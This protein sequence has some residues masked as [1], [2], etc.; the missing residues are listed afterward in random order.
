MRRKAPFFFI[1]LLAWTI[2]HSVR[3]QLHQAVTPDKPKA[4]VKQN[5]RK[6]APMET[7][8]QF[9]NRNGKWLRGMIHW[10][11]VSAGGAVPGVILFHGFTGDRN[12]SHWI[13]VKCAR[14]LQQGGIAALRFDFYGSGESEG[15]FKEMTLQGE[16]ADAEDAVGFL[17]AQNGIAFDRIGLGGL[18][19]GGTVAAS[20]AGPA[21]ARALVLWSAVAHPDHLGRTIMKS[22]KAIPNGRGNLEYDAREISAEFLE[23]LGKVNPLASVMAFKGPTLIL[24]PGKDEVVPL[25]DAEEFLNSAGAAVKEKVVIAGANHTYTSIAWENEVIQRTVAW[26]RKYL[27]DN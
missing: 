26:F 15:P 13:F 16:I 5:E 7:L 21:Q 20:I 17:R 27:F 22:G 23:G 12:E 18:S 2:A 8:V 25:S 6:H 4:D 9:K 11:A 24:Q 1:L 14:A 3:A 19:L 10:P